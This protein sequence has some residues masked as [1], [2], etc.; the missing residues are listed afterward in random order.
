MTSFIREARALAAAF[1]IFASGMIASGTAAVGTAAS[2]TA[3]SGST[4]TGIA[5]VGGIVTSL[6]A[7]AADAQDSAS[8]VVEKDRVQITLGRPLLSVRVPKSEQAGYYRW[9]FDVLSDS[10]TRAVLASIVL[11]ADSAMRSANPR[12][13]VRGST[14]RR[15]A[16]PGDVSSRRCTIVLNDSARVDGESLRVVIRDSFIVA[17]MWAN[18]PRTVTGSVFQPGGRFRVDQMGVRFVEPDTSNR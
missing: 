13:I 14:L 8:V 17:L 4:L 10:T 6:F 11:A 2:G 5:L 3:A 12:D 18:R 9:R 7:E 1:G 16:E 15:C